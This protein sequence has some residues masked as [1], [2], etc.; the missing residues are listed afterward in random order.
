MSDKQNHR[1]FYHLTDEQLRRQGKTADEITA[2]RKEQWPD[3]SK[4][5]VAPAPAQTDAAA[6]A[7]NAEPTPAAEG[8]RGK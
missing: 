2:I 5:D 4:D 7:P 1:E 3:A 6:V 8:K